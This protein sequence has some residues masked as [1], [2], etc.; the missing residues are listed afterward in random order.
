MED[1][2][3]LSVPPGIEGSQH[4]SALPAC[5][6]P[7]RGK[8]VHDLWTNCIPTGQEEEELGCI[9]EMLS[10]GDTTTTESRSRL[11]L[12]SLRWDKFSNKDR[13]RHTRTGFAFSTEVGEKKSLVTFRGLPALRDISGGGGDVAISLSLLPKTQLFFL[14]LTP[15][16]LTGWSPAPRGSHHAV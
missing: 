6:S 15:T 5:L 11:W 7:P 13:H 3:T 14:F 8:D 12:P 1:P 10:Q 2:P 9:L 16:S 4:L